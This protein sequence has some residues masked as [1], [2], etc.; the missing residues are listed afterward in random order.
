LEDGDLLV[1]DRGFPATWL[2]ALFSQ[3]GRHFLARIDG[4]QWPEVQAFAASGLAEQTVARPVGRDA[5]RHARALGVELLGTEIRFR[6]LR[7]ELP[8]GGV[9]ILATSLLDAEA[10]PAAD[11]AELYHGR[12]GIEIRH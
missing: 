12:W 9:E 1:L 8:G 5:R 6:L 4:A 3:R 11:F 7:V 10:Y 2:F